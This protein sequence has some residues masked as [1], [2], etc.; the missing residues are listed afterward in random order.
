MERKDPFE[1][2]E[3]TKPK[4]LTSENNSRGFKRREDQINS[5]ES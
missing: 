2:L 1:K 4:L 3:D 5:E